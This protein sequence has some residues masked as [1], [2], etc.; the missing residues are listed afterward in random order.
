MSWTP[1]LLSLQ[2]FVR[3]KSVEDAKVYTDSH[4]AYL[5]LNRHHEAVN[6]GVSEYVK[7]QA[8]VNGVESHWSLLK[9]SIYGT[10]YQVCA[11]HL[12]R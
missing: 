8:H 11:K 9:R 7:G 3:G 12:H 1:G 2:G 5:G 10:Y 6:H 4:A